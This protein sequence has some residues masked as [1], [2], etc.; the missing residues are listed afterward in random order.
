MQGFTL[1]LSS[2]HP[3]EVGKIA[4]LLWENGINTNETTYTPPNPKLDSNR[5]EVLRLLITLSSKE[6]YA[7]RI[8]KFLVVMTTSLPEFHIICLSSSILNLV[9]RSCRNNSDDNGLTYPPNS[10]QNVSRNSNPRALRKALVAA[11]VQ[12]LNISLLCPVE[13]PN[14]S[15][16]YEF[17]Y[18]LNLYS[19]SYT[20]NNLVKSYLG[21]LNR[22]FDLKF[23]LVNLVTLLKRP[24]DQAI[25]SE[26]NPFSLLN[27]STSATTK[28][29][30]SHGKVNGH[31]RSGSIKNGSQNSSLPRLPGLILQIVILLWELIKCNRAFENYV[32]DKYANKLLLICIYY[33]KYY[34]NITT[35][36]TNLIPVIS[37]FATYLSSKKLVMSKMLYCFN[38][39]YYTNKLPNFYKISTGDITRLTYRDFAVIQLSNLALTQVHENLIVDGTLVEL[40]YNLLPMSQELT[41][42]DLVQLSSDRSNRIST[43]SYNACVVLLQLLSKMTNKHYLTTFAGES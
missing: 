19:T 21:S 26:A 36:R 5:L 18:G 20:I 41:S 14:Q 8:S 42:G 27:S 22:E 34:S 43:L 25:E 11:S 31:S 32:A 16:I 30:G 35:W 28:Q 7:D 33:I 4:F 29:T 39:N 15:K 13:G 6:L 17:L 40:I 37:A 3:Q 23:V 1:P 2:P 38:V 12:L 10:Y 9:C 24:M